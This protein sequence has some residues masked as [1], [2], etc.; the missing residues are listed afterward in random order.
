MGGLYCGALANVYRALGA[1]LVLV[2]YDDAKK[3]AYKRMGV[4]WF[5]GNWLIF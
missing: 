2:I 1:T 4:H 5:Y 3:W